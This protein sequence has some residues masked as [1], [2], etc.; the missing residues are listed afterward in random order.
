M[1]KLLS[2]LP[3]IFFSF[4]LHAQQTEDEVFVGKGKTFGNYIG[5]AIIIPDFDRTV[6]KPT[7]DLTRL[8]GTVI[9]VGLESRMD[10]LT[11]KRVSLYSFN[12]KKIDGTIVTVGTRD[13]G[14]T[15][16]KEIVGKTI[17]VEGRKRRDVKNDAQQ[18]I[19]F[20]ATGILIVE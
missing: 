10:S 6:K 1:K 12:L 16:P 18:N 15:V 8:T 19:Q 7:T 2:I 9:S 13:N 17:T 4:A 3:V 20:A 5:T 14:F 11:D